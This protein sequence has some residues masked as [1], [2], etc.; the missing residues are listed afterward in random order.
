[1]SF[2]IH[3]LPLNGRHLIEASAGTGK[4]YTISG[5]VLRLLLER[6]LSI[7]EIL[8]VTY[9]EA[10]TEDLRSRV[11]ERIKE[12]MAAFAA[13]YGKDPFLARLLSEQSDEEEANRLLTEALR[14]FD[15][16]A[17]FT[18]H[19]FCRRLLLENS[20][21]TG[22]DFAAELVVDE[23]PLLQEI[24][25]DY[26]RLHVY[27]GSAVWVEYLA[28]RSSPEE[29][30]ELLSRNLH[31]SSLAVLPEPVAMDENQLTA[32]AERFLVWFAAVR[33]AWPLARAEVAA[34]LTEDPGLS[35]VRYKLASIPGWL[36]A[37]DGLCPEVELFDN[38][39]RFTTSALAASVKKEC[40]PPAHP[41]FDLCEELREG[42]LELGEILAGRFLGF[43][44]ELFAYAR[45]ELA[46]RKE[47]LAL[48]GFDDL[49]QQVHGA[50]QGPAG[51]E[52]AR[53]IRRR[54]PA[55]LIDE[56]QDTDPVQYRIFAA[57][58]CRPEALLFLIGDPKQAIYGFRGA[59]IFAYLRACREVD[60]RHTM[61]TNYRSASGLVRAVNLIFGRPA[62]PFI[63][64]EINFSEVLPAQRE[65]GGLR[66][67]TDDLEPFQ[68]W[69][70][71]RDA[72]EKQLAKEEGRQRL[73]RAMTAEIV[74]LLTLSRAGRATI[75]GR[76]LAAG[77]LAVLVRTNRE[78][79][80]VQETL[81]KH[82]V[83]SVLHSM[84][85]LFATRE[86]VEMARLLAAVAEPADE[87][88]VRLALVTSLCGLDGRELV[89]LMED[90]R[91]WEEKLLLFREYHELWR[92]HG[93]IRMFRYLLRR[94]GVRLG[95]LKLP[96]GERR[97]TNVLH[98]MEVLHR[99][100]VESGLGMA[101]LRNFLADRLGATDEQVEEHLLRLESDGAR[102]R[103]VTIH[104]AKGLEYPVV[105]CP[106]AW[107]KSKVSGDSFTFHAGESETVTLDLGSSD[108]DQH[109]QLAERENLAENLRLLYVALTR[110]RE[111]C[112]F[113]WGGMKEVESSAPAYLL[114]QAASPPAERSGA[115]ATRVKLMS[116]SV[117]RGEL[118]ALAAASGGAI[119]LRSVKNDEP[120]F[121]Q[122]V[123]PRTEELVCRAFT[124][125]IAADWRVTSYSGLVHGG[126]QR[127][128]EQ[129]DHDAFA[130]PK[131]TSNGILSRDPQALTIFD[132]P[133]G[134]G[135]GTFMHELLEHL[136]FTDP[137]LG[138]RKQLV[139]EKLAAFG[140]GPEWAGSLLA[141]LDQ[142]LA[143]PLLP[144]Q[145]EFMLARVQRD[146][147]LNE[148]EFH[149][150]LAMKDPAGLGRI[151]A[152]SGKQWAAAAGARLA[153]LNL[154]EMQGF[155]KGYIDLVFGV[156]DRY[157]IIDW[158][159]NFLGNR[160]EE[161]RQE[162][163]ARVMADELYILQ[164][165]LYC[166]ALHRYLASRIVDYRYGDHFGG[167]FYLFLRGMDRNLGPEYGVFHDRPAVELLEEMGEVLGG[168]RANG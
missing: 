91:L 85:N 56:F 163:L 52:L 148:M 12:G 41:F 73:L 114:H 112:Y 93:F 106:F 44:A 27:E 83:D 65:G 156:N 77:D 151:L 130:F 30:L 7:R 129:P 159:S 144:D 103:I 37:M 25:E 58:Y 137:D 36:A 21:E 35:R 90:E 135:P 80:Q 125:R 18:I 165:H 11:R 160:P 89:A 147:R 17:I 46:A 133:Q 61:G 16:A 76:P 92:D 33:N 45:Q 29:L 2:D 140:F 128:Q 59:D 20:M 69:F 118:E 75:D 167:V 99:A 22:A 88:K 28:G 60:S 32:A 102:V 10:A 3:T 64:E 72:E 34:I 127:Q 97:L 67:E 141:M 121:W 5:L 119:G 42:A 122:P 19:A 101:G 120:G 110:A 49:L 63:F 71:E 74:R 142:V 138:T 109:R 23:K 105:F 117:M 124:G 115:T 108:I 62:A 96:D 70:V 95:L 100:A 84:E 149:F 162:R 132:F 43:K 155:C 26:W 87:T 1:M 15:E 98:L 116:D 123:H 53:E 4:T 55:A 94:E 136:D 161:Y 134:A 81:L 111:R 39:D 126:R 166:L 104:K 168:V 139:L 86:A 13:G 57:V 107:Q 150:P 82:G 131:E 9:T 152:G 51:P 40:L 24:V 50:L 8:V 79:R 6:R 48:F 158:K 78:A 146:Q 164:Y 153:R 31:K 145:P 14:D 54:Y 47:R 38:F 66:L 68:L 143:T 113:A 154:P 157:Y